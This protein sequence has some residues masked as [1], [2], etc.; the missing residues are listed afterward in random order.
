[1]RVIWKRVAFLKVKLKILYKVSNHQCATSI[2]KYIQ[3]IKRIIII[4]MLMTSW[5]TI[6][7]VW[8]NIVHHQLNVEF[9]HFIMTLL[10][11]SLQNI[12][13][14]TSVISVHWTVIVIVSNMCQRM[15]FV[16]FRPV[17][18]GLVLQWWIRLHYFI[19]HL[20]SPSC[21][22]NLLSL[23]FWTLKPI[24]LQHYLGFFKVTWMTATPFHFLKFFSHFSF[25][26]MSIAKLLTYTFL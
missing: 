22:P 25:L 15:N 8:T 13:V 17:L 10:A 3:N 26:F 24:S 16:A 14:C 12:H 20:L 7:L 9:I 2:W 21:L 6:D 5:L 11:Q 1:M 4:F 18:A 19:P 23:F